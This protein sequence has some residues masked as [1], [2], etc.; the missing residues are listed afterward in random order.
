MNNAYSADPLVIRRLDAAD[1]D[2]F[3][4][5]RLTALREAPAA[6]STDGSD[7]ERMGAGA[8]ADRLARDV[9]LG[10]EVSQCL[11]GIVGMQHQDGPKHEHR[12]IVWGLYV[13]PR[14]RRNGIARQLMHALELEVDQSLEILELEVVVGNE[15]ARHLYM[16]LGYIVYGTQCKALKID[17][18]YYDR[19]LMYKELVRT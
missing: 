1:A 7:E 14:R 8:A 18:I 3:K 16:D 5:L 17:G 10:A 15:P 2:N 4:A 6:F 9:V 19:L 12:G 13:L 11:V